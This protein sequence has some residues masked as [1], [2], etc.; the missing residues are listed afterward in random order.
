MSHPLDWLGVPVLLASGYIGYRRGFLEE[1][2]RLVELIIASLISVRFYGFL[3]NWL[4]DY[5]SANDI[6]LRIVSFLIILIICLFVI[7]FLTRWIQYSILDRGVDMVNSS[8]GVLFGLLRGS[9]IILIILWLVE[10]VPG[11]KTVG[12]FKEQSYLYNHLE[13]YRYWI[14]NFSGIEPITK[15][16]EEWL[17]EKLGNKTT[18]QPRRA[19]SSRDKE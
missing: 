6:L 4:Q 15:K 7:R 19:I 5:L 9:V 1:V 16:S 10:I 11:T 2:A 18:E 17:R 13:G 8:V 3:R 14:K 12:D